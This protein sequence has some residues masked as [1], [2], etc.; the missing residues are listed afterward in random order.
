MRKVGPLGSFQSRTSCFGPNAKL[1]VSLSSREGL[2]GLNE[3]PRIYFNDMLPLLR[4][5]PGKDCRKS[6][7]LEA[8]KVLRLTGS[9]D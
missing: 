9:T 8:T 1:E 2:R 6:Y 3:W 7:A 4:L 5:E